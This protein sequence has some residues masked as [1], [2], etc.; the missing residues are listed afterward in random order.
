VHSYGVVSDRLDEAVELFPTREE[1]AAVVSAWDRDEPDQAG[2][3][4]VET[5]EFET[6][7]T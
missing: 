5:V 1:A 7:L 6:S 2:T 3:L 4:R